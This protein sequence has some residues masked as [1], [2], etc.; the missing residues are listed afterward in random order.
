MPIPSEP[1]ATKTPV[2]TTSEPETV[3]AP[4]P[5]PSQPATAKTL[6]MGWWQPPAAKAPAPIASEPVGVKTP[7][8][9]WSEPAA[10]ET[11]VPISSEPATVED[12]APAPPAALPEASLIAESR[13]PT[14]E[15]T[16][17]EAEAASSET[18][19]SDVP[20]AYEPPAA[21]VT[22]SQPDGPSQAQPWLLAA[23]ATPP[24]AETLAAQPASP[25]VETVAAAGPPVETPAAQPVRPPVDEPSPVPLETLPS[26]V[27]KEE[28]PPIPPEARTPPPVSELPS[29]GRMSAAEESDATSRRRAVQGGRRTLTP[30]PRRMLT[31][32]PLRTHSVT[33]APARS[34]VVRGGPWI[35]YAV[36]GTLAALAMCT[37]VVPLAV[38]PHSPA[39]VRARVLVVKPAAVLRWFDGTALVEMLPGQVLSFPAGGKVIRLASPGTPL[40]SGDVVAAT[41]AA[42]PALADLARLQERLAY[43]QQLKEGMQDTAD[44]KRA[45]AAR[46]RVESSAGLV[47][48]AQVA[49]SRVAVMASAP[50]Q[51]ERTLATLGQTVRA[52]APAV[53]LRSAGWRAAFE[54]PR[55]LVARVRK[56]GFCVAEVEGRPVACSLVPDGGD[57]THLVTELPPEAATAAGRP[58]RL[59]RAR[60]ADA[61]VVPASA[62][63][64]VGD[65]DR[66]LVVAP[67]GRAE[68]RTVVVADRIAADAVITQ[69]LDAGDA[70]IVETSQ[71]IGAGV[72]VRIT[73][74]TRE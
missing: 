62:L 28:P 47:G 49:L 5:S 4:V 74:A 1:A 67:T 46:A 32:P 15:P 71:P 65:S 72:R 9:V 16:P 37:L 35:R 39:A 40:Q 63:S 36:L 19:S 42:S 17:P 50:G 51:V 44:E 54:L 14:E 12:H 20:P 6:L 13:P 52:G 61:F 3:A 34:A 8:P 18:P 53:R 31:P 7:V 26:G 48:Q 30:G 33:A 23:D 38:R 69:G 29:R 25:P 70:I 21:V 24:P 27:L 43:F 41:D 73:E 59:A 68:A 2:P 10:A 45:A 56:Q 64:H 60:L 58:V 11:P 66:V 57:E 22:T 55:T